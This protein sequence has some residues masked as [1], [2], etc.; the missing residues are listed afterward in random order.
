VRARLSTSKASLLPLTST[1]NTWPGAGARI[2]RGAN[3]AFAHLRPW[4][5]PRLLLLPFAQRAEKQWGSASLPA[6]WH[7]AA[8]LP[9]CQTR[10]TH[11]RF[12]AGAHLAAGH[13]WVHIHVAVGARLVVRQAGRAEPLAAPAPPKTASVTL[14]PGPRCA[15]GHSL[16]AGRLVLQH[17]LLDS[18]RLP[19]WCRQPA[20]GGR[21]LVASRWQAEGRLP[22]RRKYFG[23][24]K[25]A[26]CTYPNWELL[27][28]KLVSSRTSSG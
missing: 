11:S 18:V 3:D 24:R 16:P 12:H 19:G 2:L 17:T 27:Q 22:K 23:G 21:A 8:L 26:A 25:L 13:E 20:A 15:A 9:C 14:L 1:R 10:G 6:R 28:T 7:N 4:L 5:A